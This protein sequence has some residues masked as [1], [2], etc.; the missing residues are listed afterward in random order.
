[1]SKIAKIVRIYKKSA[2]MQ[3]KIWQNFSKNA[4]NLSKIAKS[5]QKL[6]KIAEIQQ[7]LQYLLKHAEIIQFNSN[8]QKT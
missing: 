2:G 7:K 8:I 4:M 5:C 1:L 3:Q 6:L